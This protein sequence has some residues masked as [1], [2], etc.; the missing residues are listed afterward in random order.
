MLRAEVQILWILRGSPHRSVSAEFV[1]RNSFDGIRSTAFVRHFVRGISLTSFDFV[2]NRTVVLSE[3][4]I[5]VFSIS[6][7]RGFILSP[8]RRLFM[9][10]RSVES[11]FIGRSSVRSPQ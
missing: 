6:L 1:W 9:Q 3:V 10:M 8:P 4:S 2:A 11:A 5:E 7:D